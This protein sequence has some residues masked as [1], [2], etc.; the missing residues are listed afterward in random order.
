MTA[1]RTL[2]LFGAGASFGSEPDG[3]RVP[4]L[5]EDLY[6]N[7]RQFSPNV[8]G[9]LPAPY[10]ELFKRDFEDAFRQLGNDSPSPLSPDFKP[11]VEYPA[12]LTGPLLREM[13][14]FFLEFVPTD[15]NLYLRLAER[16]KKN[17]WRGVLA[18]LNY[19]LLLPSALDKSRVTAC[20]SP[21][22]DNCLRLCLPHGCSALLIEPGRIVGQA[23]L[24]GLGNRIEGTAVVFERDVRVARQRLRDEFVP[25]VMSYFEPSKTVVTAPEF[26]VNQR[27]LLGNAIDVADTIVIIGVRVRE[28][29][30]HI[31]DH[32]QSTSATL[33]Y[34][35]PAA[36]SINEFEC[37]ARVTR[38][39]RTYVTL[40][41]SFQDAFD[42]ICRNARVG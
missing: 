3:V 41:Y 37:W 17:G 39:D 16:M 34:C 14:E 29:D 26:L 30:R 5:C 10:P 7:L 25:P 22:D 38:P 28:H 9:A 40:P 18:S 6:D 1:N 23:V 35:S 19:D 8:W 24:V 32:L 15:N 31:W 42:E 33:V 12:H 20:L 2:I 13:A 21:W 11:T 36:V 27:T 4:P